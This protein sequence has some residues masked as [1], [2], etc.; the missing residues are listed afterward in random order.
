MAGIIIQYPLLDNRIILSP[1]VAFGNTF[2]TKIKNDIFELYNGT[3]ATFAYEG[4]I[5]INYYLHK[6]WFLS[7]FAKYLHVNNGTAEAKGLYYIPANNLNQLQ[8]G[9]G[10]RY[11][12]L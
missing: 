6:G 4:G 8:V 7:G 9:I 1:Y 5:D 10:A 12:F 3:G 11:S 2:N